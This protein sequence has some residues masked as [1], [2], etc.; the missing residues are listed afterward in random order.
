M[1][2]TLRSAFCVINNPRYD[3]KYLYDTDGNIVINPD[4]EK[5]IKEKLNNEFTVLSDKELAEKIVDL[6]ISSKEGRSAACSVCVSSLGLEHLHLVV[7]CEKSQKFTFQTL[8]KIYGDK[9]HIEPT[10]GTKE[11]ALDY[12][13]KRGKFEDKGEIVK[14][15]YL[16]GNISGNQGN[17]TDLQSIE[18]LINQGYKPSY[19]LSQ[20]FK[21]FKNETMIRSAYMLKRFNDTPV[22]R[23]I[24][25]VWHCGKSGSGKSYTYVEL[26]N[27]YGEDEVF[28]I[29][30]Y[31]SGMFDNYEGQKIL[32]LDEFKEYSCTY[33]KLLTIIDKYKTKFQCRYTN[34]YSLWTEVHIS[35]IYKPDTYYNILHLNSNDSFEQLKRRINKIV[36]HKKYNDNYLREEI[37]GNDYYIGYSFN[38]EFNN[39]SSLPFK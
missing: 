18:E 29:S 25:V 9:I 23:D 3:I 14:Y 34:I 20:D 11:Q 22:I 26:C 16:V 13:Y 15:T 5:V 35:S 28:K 32:F 31:G 38:L 33:A 8:K 19:I 37:K 1:Q 39:D 21:Y 4:G 24:N 10:R 6:W 27:L 7:C 30:D 36:Y 2:K 12:I 17:R